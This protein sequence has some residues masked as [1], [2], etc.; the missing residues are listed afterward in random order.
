LA[1]LAA[2]GLWAAI[3]PDFSDGTRYSGLLSE[4]L[5]EDPRALTKRT[6]EQSKHLGVPKAGPFKVET[7]RY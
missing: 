2:E 1:L 6:P 3:L 5:G 7:N 4:A